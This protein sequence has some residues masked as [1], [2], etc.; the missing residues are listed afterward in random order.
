MAGYGFNGDL[1]ALPQRSILQM[2]RQTWDMGSK[3]RIKK[4]Q[5]NRIRLYAEINGWQ[6]TRHYWRVLWLL[7]IKIIL[8]DEKCNNP[9]NDYI[10]WENLPLCKRHR[11][12]RNFYLHKGVNSWVGNGFRDWDIIDISQLTNDFWNWDGNLPCNEFFRRRTCILI[13]CLILRNEWGRRLQQCGLHYAI[14]SHRTNEHLPIHKLMRESL[15]IN[16]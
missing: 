13:I 15:A 9:A 10:C 5:K 14:Q 11:L 12:A 7:I 3:N 6:R 8:N 4:K 16:T 1:F 2:A